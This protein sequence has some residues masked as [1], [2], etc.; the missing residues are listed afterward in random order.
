MIGLGIGRFPSFPDRRAFFLACALPLWPQAKGEDGFAVPQTGSHPRQL[1]FAEVLAE[2]RCASEIAGHLEVDE[3]EPPLL[4]QQAVPHN[5]VMLM[6]EQVV[7]RPPARRVR[8]CNYQVAK[9][10]A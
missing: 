7:V 5:S 8:L 3:P 6:Q 1:R 9:Q 4:P 10:R 2:V